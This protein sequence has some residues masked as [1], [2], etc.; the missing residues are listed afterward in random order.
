MSEAA[1]INNELALSVPQVHEYEALQNTLATLDPG[2]A[3]CVLEPFVESAPRVAM[4]H[5]DLAVCHFRS[6]N[7]AKAERHYIAALELEP[8]HP[9]FLKNLADYYHI[10]Q[11]RLQE[12]MAL[13]LRVLQ[14]NPDDVEVLV[15][16]GMLNLSLQF[17]E[18][19]LFFFA[20]VRQ[21]APD[22]PGL[23]D[24]MAQLEG[25][26]S[27]TSEM[28]DE[29]DLDADY[30]RGLLDLPATQQSGYIS[31]F[32]SR[33]PQYAR[34]HN[35]LGVLHYQAEKV[36]A[37][38]QCY[39]RAVRLAP[40]DIVFR[41]NLADLW[42]IEKKDYSAAVKNYL[43]VLKQ[44]P[45]DVEALYGVGCISAING[46][47]D[48]A[49]EFFKHVLA[50]APDH[51]DARQQFARIS[52]ADQAV[53]APQADEPTRST[54]SSPMAASDLPEV[55]SAAARLQA[56]VADTAVFI[57]CDSDN[58]PLRACL[59]SLERHAVSSRV[60]IL[61]RHI[62]PAMVDTIRR[63]VALSVHLRLIGEN[64]TDLIQVLNT[65]LTVTKCSYLL[66]MRPDVQVCADWLP[67]LLEPV[68][69]DPEIALVNPLFC[70][71]T[72]AEQGIATDDANAGLTPSYRHRQ[73]HVTRSDTACLALSKSTFESIGRFDERFEDYATAVIDW[74]LRA[75]IKGL[76]L[77]V[78]GDLVL[79][80]KTRN[81]SSAVDS[82]ALEQNWHRIKPSSE[83]G[84]AIRELQLIEE[85]EY[86][87][88]G[89]RVSALVDRLV[90]LGPE[91][92]TL[93]SH[94][95][96]AL[97]T[98]IELKQFEIAD[99]L[100]QNFQ[101]DQADARLIS[102]YGYIKDGLGDWQAALELSQTAL[103]KQPD[104]TLAWN[105]RGVIAAHQDEPGLSESC[106]KKAISLNPAYGEAYANL[107]TL[108][109]DESVPKAGFDLYEKA[110]ILSPLS[111]DILELYQ[112]AVARLEQYERAKP[113]VTE[114]LSHHRESLLL[115][116]FQIDLAL[117]TN[118]D[119]E[120][121]RTIQDAILRFGLLDGILTPALAIREK[122][123]PISSLPSATKDPSLSVCLII[124]N[125]EACLAKCLT[126]VLGLADEIV[127]VD[128]GSDDRSVDIARVFGAEVFHY[129]WNSDFS[130]ARNVYLKKAKGD[131][132]L[133][134]D[135]DEVIAMCDHEKIRALIR[136]GQ[137]KPI[138]YT[139]TTRNYDSNPTIIGWTANQ[140]EYATEE[141]GNGWI[142]TYKIRLFPND[143]R[144]AY[145]FP[146]HEMLEPSLKKHGFELAPAD[147]PVHHYGKLN[148][149][150]TK[151]KY[152]LYYKLG[153][154]KLK[155]TG[156]DPFSLRE[157]A[158]QAGL[159][160]RYDEA[161]S[162]WQR[163]IDIKPD[164]PEAYINMGTAYFHLGRYGQAL[165][166][167]LHA[168]EIA[169]DFRE[170]QYNYAI[171]LVHIGK[172]DE[173]IA[174]LK[175]LC[176]KHPNYLPAC[177]LLTASSFAVEDLEAGR[178]HLENLRKTPLGAVL[179]VSFETFI[180]G[181][182]RAN[183][184]RYARTVGKQALALQVGNVA[185]ERMVQKIEKDICTN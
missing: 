158:I 47:P 45:Q 62:D 86:D 88:A 72:L 118:A 165:K 96:R 115:T 134:L 87:Y 7:L 102:L 129:E 103:Q 101:A 9:L 54:S 4:A 120:A 33:H 169:P 141:C 124:K 167:S 36:E 112:Q 11:H 185:I 138:A 108:T 27:A 176:E 173:A 153:L 147:V 61:S 132:I 172:A 164:V 10:A 135:A 180:T 177:F 123:G 65:E 18:D 84:R 151:E 30:A 20:K 174:V 162:L 142:P 78:A 144:L 83:K 116:Y 16:I 24:V 32:L 121:M 184:Y 110:F 159:L 150:K 92:L 136:E 2:E 67:R 40:L 127:V 35:D 109:W 125:E 181:L 160:Q 75:R 161:I 58:D 59:K 111:E 128:T 8:S 82:Q 81:S 19:A 107:A 104:C 156:D 52:A 149:E 56:A 137:E 182:L 131:W 57:F 145:S 1:V 64:P 74:A 171:V 38:L 178:S 117:N 122:L 85:I 98:L 6:G 3:I 63:H 12:A 94:R 114:A 166:Q 73:I 105:L 77:A 51:F 14:Q 26:T 29:M 119:L 28:P 69:V 49:Q 34:A 154:K 133:V 39:Q 175:P 55:R 21:V 100:A 106:F 70:E 183:Q 126:S 139:I 155:E 97:N 44:D 148:L 66:M 68:V 31:E 179:S 95:A 25:E 71:T 37:A 157:L 163:F 113:I 46:Q 143:D 140:G 43:A 168:I 76:R 89:G 13:Y 130:A 48:T 53:V 23:R 50:I 15:A 146:V 79:E 22:Y 90:R 60:T 170:S 99:R 93:P 152:A 17:K 42:F 5:N 41:K 80:K 91:D